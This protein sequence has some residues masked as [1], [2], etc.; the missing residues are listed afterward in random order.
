MCPVP[1]ISAVGSLLSNVIHCNNYFAVTGVEVDGTDRFD[2]STDED[3]GFN[4]V[5][6]DYLKKLL[7][8]K[9]EIQLKQ[10]T[11]QVN[12]F[13][14]PE[15][16]LQDTNQG[17]SVLYVLLMQYCMDDI[18]LKLNTMLFS[19]SKKTKMNYF[20]VTYLQFGVIFKAL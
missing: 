12:R 7:K 14:D 9:R 11:D 6:A 20:I 10:A 16:I 15:I 13:P 5:E 4:P 3:E 8:S 18:S 1:F 17:C 19:S 2:N